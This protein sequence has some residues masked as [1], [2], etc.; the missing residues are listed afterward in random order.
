MACDKMAGMN[1]DTD[2]L[3]IE[4]YLSPDQA[5][6]LAQF[7]KRVGWDAMRECAVDENETYRI[8]SALEQLRK[9][10][11]EEGFAPR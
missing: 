11:A 5:L 6:A 8:R 2:E 4:V 1:T 7:V 3:K 10:L 9:G